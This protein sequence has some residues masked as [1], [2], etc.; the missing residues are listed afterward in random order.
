MVRAVD[1]EPT[2]SEKHLDDQK[3]TE[4]E[5]RND[6]RV[7]V[8]K[9]IW[10]AYNVELGDENEP[11]ASALALLWETVTAGLPS[12]DADRS[13]EE[14]E[15]C[16][17]CNRRLPTPW[18]EAIHNTGECGCDSSR[19]LCWRKWNNNKCCERSPYDPEE[20]KC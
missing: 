2:H 10:R 16:T 20:R 6:E 4:Q 11:A 15:R 8:A 3:M 17:D 1:G 19:K 7:E 9:V 12:E 14:G 5:I 18:D 13:Q